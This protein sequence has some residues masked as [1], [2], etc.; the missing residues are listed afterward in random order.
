MAWTISSRF[1]WNTLAIT[2]SSGY[3]HKRSIGFSCGEYGGRDNTALL[4]AKTPWPFWRGEC[5]R[6]PTP[7][8][9]DGLDRALWAFSKNP[10]TSRH[11]QRSFDEAP[12]RHRG[13]WPRQTAIRGY[14]GRTSTLVFG[15]RLPTMWTARHGKSGYGFHRCTEEQHLLWWSSFFI[16]SIFVSN[17][18]CRS[19]FP[20]A[21]VYVGRVHHSPLRRRS[22]RR[23]WKHRIALRH[24]IA[25]VWCSMTRRTAIT[26]WRMRAFLIFRSCLRSVRGVHPWSLVMR[27]RFINDS[28]PFPYVSLGTG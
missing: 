2:V 11:G 17:C 5:G 25:G 20:F 24:R 13:C 3:F 27:R 15:G 26:R 10:R 9:W 6:Y 22:F 4:P 18:F 19:G 1:L 28:A 16:R 12:F 21:S 14:D 7:R 8:P 23:K